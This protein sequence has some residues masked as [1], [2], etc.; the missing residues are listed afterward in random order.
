MKNPNPIIG[1]IVT[2]DGQALELGGGNH[3]DVPA[4]GVLWKGLY[5]TLFPNR[6]AARGAVDRSLRYSDANDLRWGKKWEYRIYP[7]RG[8]EGQ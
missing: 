1:Y 4:A 8:R 3:A 2:I 5:A 6:K 7:V